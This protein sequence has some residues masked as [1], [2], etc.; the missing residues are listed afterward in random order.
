MENFNFK[1]MEGHKNQKKL[2][3]C[4]RQRN[5]IW[6]LV[7][8]SSVLTCLSLFAVFC[9]FLLNGKISTLEGEIERLQNKD[10]QRL[11]DADIQKILSVEVDRMIQKVNIYLFSWFVNSN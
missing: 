1:T 8:W 6:P 5:L 4:G 7:L 3:A 9:C 2:D 11:F 10:H